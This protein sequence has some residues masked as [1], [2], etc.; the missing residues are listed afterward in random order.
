MKLFLI[1]LLSN[2]FFEILLILLQG[3]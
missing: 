2:Q 3:V 1:L